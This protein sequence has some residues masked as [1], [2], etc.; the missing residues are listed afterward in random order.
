MGH[1]VRKKLRRL[2]AVSADY[3][4]EQMMGLRADADDRK[5]FILYGLLIFFYYGCVLAPALL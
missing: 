4:F 3:F 5:K 1:A 2:R